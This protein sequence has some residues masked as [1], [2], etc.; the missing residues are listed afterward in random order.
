MQAR[1]CAISSHIP[2][3]SLL[4]EW[5]VAVIFLFG[6]WISRL[7]SGFVQ[8]HGGEREAQSHGYSQFHNTLINQYMMQRIILL[9]L[10]TTEHAKD[11]V[12]TWR[13]LISAVIIS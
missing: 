4:T 13:L 8:C 9:L 3:I 5:N 7:V 1:K 12:G 2:A 10:A 6:Q 11:M